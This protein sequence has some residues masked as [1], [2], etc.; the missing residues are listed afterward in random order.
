LQ[1]YQP[2]F[3]KLKRNKFVLIRNVLLGLSVFLTS[4]DKD[5]VNDDPLISQGREL[6]KDTRF[7][8]NH[9]QSCE[10]C[11]PHGH[12]DGKLWHFPAIHGSTS[13]KPDSV[14]TLTIWGITETGPPYLWDGSRWDLAGVTRLYTDTIMGGN[15][16]ADE[17]DALVAYQKSLLF[18]KSPWVNDDGTLNAAQQRG[19]T[20]YETKGL[21]SPCH[22]APVGS[23]RFTKNIGTGGVFRTPGLRWMFS[24]APYYHDGR[25]KSLRDVVNFY[26]NDTSGTLHNAG[27]DIDLTESEK[28]DLLEY[29]KTF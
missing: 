11:H 9:D 21:C 3:V 8:T 29:M 17:I 10:T 18:P 23:N 19:K 26:A 6:F 7:S 22:P 24:E 12:M 20:I 1:V 14:R 4:C 2:D 27:F 25:A 16:T 15:A 28:D 5:A 13:G